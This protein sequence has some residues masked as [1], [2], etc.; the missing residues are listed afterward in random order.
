MNNVAL[1]T[2]IGGLIGSESARFFADKEFHIIGID[3][4]MRARLFGEQASIALNLQKLVTDLGN[5]IT[6][7]NADIRYYEQLESIFER[8]T[9]NIKVIIHCAAQPSHDWAAKEPITDFE[10]NAVGTLNI[11]ELA[12]L[13]CPKATIIFTSSNKVYGDRPNIFN[14]DEDQTRYSPAADHP[15]PE[16]FPE[17]LP[18]DQSTHSVF[19]VSKVAADIMAQE[20]GRYYGMNTGVFRGGCL[21]GPAHA[22]AEQHGFLA[23]LVKCITNY[24]NYTIYGYKGKQVRDNIHSYDLVNAFWHYYQN[25]KVGEVYNIGGGPNRTC[26]VLEALNTVRDITGIEPLYNYIEQPRRGDH[27]W[28]ATDLGKFQSDYPDWNFKFSLDDIVNQLI[29][30]NKE[31]RPNEI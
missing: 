10:I 18:I 28:Y 11:L 23:Y 8:H 27:I 1:I 21:T 19:G 31:R 2:G 6:Y 15:W 24:K 3:N 7:C 16:G 26:S 4:N 9:D 13:N 29:Q 20:Y 14:Y 12:R 5:K 17:L 22:G 25:P 30:S